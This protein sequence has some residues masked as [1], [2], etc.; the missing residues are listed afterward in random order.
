MVFQ[1]SYLQW[2]LQ[3][4]LLRETIILIQLISCHFKAAHTSQSG[5]NMVT[6]GKASRIVRV[7]LVTNHEH[8]K[9]NGPFWAILTQLFNEMKLWVMILVEVMGEIYIDLQGPGLHS[10]LY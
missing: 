7:V 4:I 9:S 2:N 1:S 10:T 3:I 6:F 5:S 8:F